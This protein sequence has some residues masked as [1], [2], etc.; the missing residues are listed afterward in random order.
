LR[1]GEAAGNRR[2]GGRDAG[3]RGGYKTLRAYNE[4]KV[5]G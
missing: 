1:E 5:E 3:Y 4:R 2:C